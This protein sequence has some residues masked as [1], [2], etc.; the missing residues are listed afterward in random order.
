MKC[1]IGDTYS[2]LGTCV[3]AS[4]DTY[5]KRLYISNERRPIK[6]RDITVDID[7]KNAR[8]RDLVNLCSLFH[9]L[10]RLSRF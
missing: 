7:A 8:F 6:P 4:F 1:A 10:D 9:T 3:R 2:S 5:L